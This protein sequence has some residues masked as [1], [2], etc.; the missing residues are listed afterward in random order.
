VGNNTPTEEPNMTNDTIV[1]VKGIE[2]A[3]SFD[4][5]YEGVTVFRLE[6]MSIPAKPKYCFT[7]GEGARLVASQREAR[8]AIKAGK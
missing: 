5:E 7:L 2:Y 6:R 8:D 4:F 3:M 1:L